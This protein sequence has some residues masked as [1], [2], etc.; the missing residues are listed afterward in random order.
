MV[1]VEPINLRCKLTGA[2]HSA[3]LPQQGLSFLLL[4]PFLQSQAQGPWA[5]CV[6]EEVD[7]SALRNR[8]IGLQLDRSVPSAASR[9]ADGTH[10]IASDYTV[11]NICITDRKMDS[12]GW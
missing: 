3:H 4:K 11:S 10:Y 12:E 7:A 2:T 9:S 8:I 1:P 6:H 5:F